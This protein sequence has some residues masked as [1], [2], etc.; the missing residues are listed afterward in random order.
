M[1][2]AGKVHVL[3]EIYGMKNWPQASYHELRSFGTYIT[4]WHAAACGQ[5]IDGPLTYKMPSHGRNDA[6]DNS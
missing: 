6:T 2:V 3:L 5:L 4:S 1:S